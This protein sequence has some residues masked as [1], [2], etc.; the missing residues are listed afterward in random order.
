VDEDGKLRM[1]YDNQS[2]EMVISVSEDKLTLCQPEAS[3]CDAYQK[4][5][6]VK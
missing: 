5:Q 2:A 6:K 3:R 4:V 1:D